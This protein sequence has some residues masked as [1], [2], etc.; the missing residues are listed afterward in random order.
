MHSCYLF[1]SAIMS[2]GEQQNA[3]SNVPPTT[4]RQIGN[5]EPTSSQTQSTTPSS[6]NE[7][8]YNPLS[9]PM[10][11]GQQPIPKRESS[12]RVWNHSLQCLK[13]EEYLSEAIL[14]QLIRRSLT[15]EAAE[16]LVTLPVSATG[17]DILT[18]LT[19]LYSSKPV[20]FDGWSIFHGASQATTESVTEWKVRLMRLFDE[21]NTQGRFNEHRD[22]M[23]ATAFWHNLCNKDLRIATSSDREKPFNC[24]FR[25]VKE[26]E[27]LYTSKPIK[28]AKSTTTFSNELDELK[29]QMQALKTKNKELQDLVKPKSETKTRFTP[30]CFSCGK[31]GHISRNCSKRIKERKDGVKCEFCFRPGHTQEKC[32]VYKHHK[33][34]GNLKG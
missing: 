26:N 11:S 13:Q 32:F 2:D 33:D 30:T 14:K 4:R 6:T 18:E 19:D 31:E 3:I 29:K 23:L 17:E 15:G 7:I 25:S 20:R 27:L 28:P 22:E 10:F 9:L 16:S 21:A 1:A 12:F 24:L 34:Q 8:R 5:M